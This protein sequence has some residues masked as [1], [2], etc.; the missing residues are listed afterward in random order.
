MCEPEVESPI[1]LVSSGIKIINLLLFSHRIPLSV[2]VSISK[3]IV[4]LG[5]EVQHYVATC[6]PEQVSVAAMVVRRIIWRNA[7]M[8][9][10]E[11]RQIMGLTS[12]IH[13][14]R[15]DTS[16]LHHHIVTRSGHC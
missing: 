1:T 14:G 16:T 3:D 2:S 6:D 12:S 5:K 13:V 11:S 8:T 10:C 9:S 4:H 15:N 7:L